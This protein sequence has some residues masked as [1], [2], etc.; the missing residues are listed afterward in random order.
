MVAPRDET[1]LRV[2]EPCGDV[3]LSQGS[4][5]PGAGL[6]QE[7]RSGEGACLGKLTALPWSRCDSE[8][9]DRVERR[10]ET[11]RDQAPCRSIGHVGFLACD[12]WL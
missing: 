3:G 9:V 12:V 8:A 10:A 6:V 4:T 11:N 7:R 5:C 1:L 2:G